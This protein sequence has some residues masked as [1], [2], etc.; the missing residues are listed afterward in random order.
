MELN[1]GEIAIK[2]SLL[3][4][5]ESDIF[6]LSV[7]TEC[8]HNNR[9]ITIFKNAPFNHK[10]SSWIFSQSIWLIQML[11]KLIMSRLCCWKV[12]YYWLSLCHK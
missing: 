1:E 8:V 11:L 4:L 12:V 5:D 7:L 10:A 9:L 6:Y 3:I 2:I